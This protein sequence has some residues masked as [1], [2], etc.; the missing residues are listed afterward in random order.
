MGVYRKYSKED[1]KSLA[2]C[3]ADWA[4]HVL[5]HFE[6]SYPK[7]KRPR[8]AIEAW[9][10]WV[11]TGLFKMSDVRVA[12]LSAHAAAR[13]A[14]N[15]KVACFAARADGQA[16]ATSHVPQHA[17]GAAYYALKTVAA[18]DISNSEV[19]TERERNR[20]SSRLPA[21]LRKEFLKR[22]I[23]QKDDHK[24]S[25]KIKRGKGF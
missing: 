21:H 12:S 17:F 13:K 7:D 22:V 11:R 3:A 18:I 24:I 1:Q 25:I 5:P 8:E 23:I 14:K 15:D 2:S 10:E 6:K 20:Q 4:Q 19:K 9:R 16:I